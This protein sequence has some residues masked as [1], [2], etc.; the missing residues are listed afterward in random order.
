M[1]AIRCG[2]LLP[3]IAYHATHNSLSIIC[4]GI[5]P[6]GPNRWLPG[7]VEPNGA[8]G[9]DYMLLPTILLSTAG[10]LILIWLWY[11]GLEKDK[12]SRPLLGLPIWRR[13]Q[14]NM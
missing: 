2:S 8:G 3:C 9:F 5:Y 4:S 10:F 7:L 1:I 13:R 14:M 6:D 12:E 11:G